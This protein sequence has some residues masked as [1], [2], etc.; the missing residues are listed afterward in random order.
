VVIG[1][2]AVTHVTDLDHDIF[3]DFGTALALLYF[4]LGGL[5]SLLSLIILI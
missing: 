4:I 5:L 2:A 3:V 1:P